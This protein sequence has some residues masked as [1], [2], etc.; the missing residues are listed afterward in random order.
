MIDIRCKIEV[1]LS[2]LDGFKAALDGPLL[3]LMSASALSSRS[4]GFPR[5]LHRVD[6]GDKKEGRVMVLDGLMHL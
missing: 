4:V 5:N 2:Q 1:R 3:I 6:R